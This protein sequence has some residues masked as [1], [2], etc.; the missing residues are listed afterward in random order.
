MALSSAWRPRSPELLG[1][2]RGVRE[3]L[4]VFIQVS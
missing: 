4:F 3:H 2:V 1:A